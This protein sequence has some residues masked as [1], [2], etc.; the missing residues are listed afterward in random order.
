MG[1]SAS[2]LPYTIGDQ[3]LETDD[4]CWAVHGGFQKSDGAPVTVFQAQKPALAKE[5]FRGGPPNLSKIFV[6]HHHFVNSK[7]LRHPYILQVLATLDTDSPSTGTS[8]DLM[9]PSNMA[10]TGAYII[11]TEPCVPLM[12]WL[13]NKPNSDQLAWGLQCMV[14]AMSFLH[15]SAQ[16]AHGDVS[17]QSFWVTPSGDVKLWNFSLVTPIGVMDG[18]GGPTKHF[19]EYEGL[20]TPQAYR[21]PERIK[22]QWQ[23]VAT[24][25]IHCMDSFSLGI[26]I[27]QYYS[28][29]V[30]GPLQKA[31]QRLQTP[32]LKMRPRLG[33]L[34]RC[35]VFDTKY[36]KLLSELEELQIQPI[37]QKLRFWQM[38]QL[39]E[40]DHNV[41]RFKILP[42]IQSTILTIC[43]SEAMLS[44]DLYRREVLAMM[45]PLFYISEHVLEEGQVGK[46]L[47]PLIRCLFVVKDRGVRGALLGKT[48]LLA[49]NL[50]QK[51]LNSRV[52]E[53]LCSGFADSSDALRELTLKATRVLVPHLYPPNVEKLSRYLVRL[54]SDTSSSIRTHTMGMIPEL[55]PH[56]SEMARQKLLLPAFIRAFRDPHPPCR[57]AALRACVQSNEYFTL[58]ELANKVLPA[59][60]PMVLDGV[61][62]VRKN[63]FD[64]IEFFISRLREN[65]KEK[66]FGEVGM[67]TVRGVNEKDITTVVPPQQPLS[68]TATETT[69]AP[70]S[71][72]YFGSMSTWYSSSA[73]AKAEEPAPAPEPVP[74]PKP[75]PKPAPAFSSLNIGGAATTSAVSDGWD[76]DEDDDDLGL[77]DDDVFASIGIKTTAAGP[78]SG[79]KLI[80]NKPT[81]GKGTTKPKPA[82]KKLAIEDDV[83]DGWDDF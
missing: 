48:P 32:S 38:L 80:M 37:E 44:Q 40:M 23:G 57:L 46:E 11:V 31:T 51:D 81:H 21:S 1:N 25:Q 33:P 39:E 55:A 24:S 7:K 65:H 43:G 74:E 76:D 29:K 61:G 16:L 22:T 35:P 2:S 70:S 20:L 60:M 3:E 82:V 50:D 45:T 28:G 47:T 4:G 9:S 72:S 83:A 77:G 41:A 63:S 56:L 26:L 13:E 69:A 17:P 49:S 8:E 59:V 36:A 78:K 5:G 62:D 14:Q 71:G 58:E 30:P 67:P 42:L 64:V 52:F 53:P 27:N 54:Q 19:R 6:A 75:A 18:G 12:Q 10:T 66:S 15:N 79:G 73:T 34:L 68:A